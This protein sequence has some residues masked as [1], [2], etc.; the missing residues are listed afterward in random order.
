MATF[1]HVIIRLYLYFLFVLFFITGGFAMFVL[2]P[3]YKSAFVPGAA[4]RDLHPFR[5]WSRAYKVVW[6]TLTD[7]SYRAAFPGMLTAPPKSHTDLRWVRV[8][9]SWRGEEKNCDLCQASCC[10]Q[11]ECAML[12]ADKR[13]MGYGSLFFAY[14]Y[15]GRYPESQSQIDYYQCPKWEARRDTDVPAA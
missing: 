3:L 7:K 12:G 11:V 4:Y 15:C 6:R 2:A 14:F 8:K 1:K 10:V 9:E 13:C 5:L